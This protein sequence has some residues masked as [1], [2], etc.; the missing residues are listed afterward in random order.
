M[1]KGEI[2]WGLKKCSFE[3]LDCY[4]QISTKISFF[5]FL[6][7]LSFFRFSTF[8]F[9]TYGTVLQIASHISDTQNSNVK[10]NSRSG[11]PSPHCGYNTSKNSK[12]WLVTFYP[13]DRSYILLSFDSWLQ[14]SKV[15]P[16]KLQFIR[17][18]R[19]LQSF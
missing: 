9:P 17:G 8:C 14:L 1:R 6:T 10:S 18:V 16:K 11:A 15:S 12:K 2:G 5:I 19:V 13:V 7:L 3:S 4:K